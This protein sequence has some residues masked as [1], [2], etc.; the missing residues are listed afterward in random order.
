M[1]YYSA[2]KLMRITTKG[3]VTIP[4]HIRK[5]AGLAP[6][7]DVEFHFESGRVW[8][9]RHEEDPAARR[10]RVR[11]TIQSVAGSA[12]ANLDMSTDDIMAMTRDD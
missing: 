12:S 9:A 5:Q 10:A 7:C 8:L 2:E 6:G 4:Q 1:Q 11:A 3:Q